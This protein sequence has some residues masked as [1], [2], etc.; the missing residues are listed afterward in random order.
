MGKHS[1]LEPYAIIIAIAI[2]FQSARSTNPP[3]SSPHSPL[4]LPLILPF[5]S[6]PLLSSLPSSLSS[7]LFFLPLLLHM[8]SCCQEMNEISQNNE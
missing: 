3:P 2:D 5:P 7:P 4:P 1:D 6:P 8:N